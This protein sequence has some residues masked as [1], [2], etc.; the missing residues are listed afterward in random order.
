[1]ACERGHQVQSEFEKAVSERTKVEAQY[2]FVH[3]TNQA[4]VDARSNE[5]KALLSRTV[6]VSGCRECWMLPPQYVS[7]KLSA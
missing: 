2:P 7:Y 5:E 4:I 3:K 1:M 6:H